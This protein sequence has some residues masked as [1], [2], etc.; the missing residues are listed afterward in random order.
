M[1]YTIPLFS[2]IVVASTFPNNPLAM[3]AY[4]AIAL[5]SVFLAANLFRR[6]S[7]P[8]M[9]QALIASS[10]ALIVAIGTCAFFYLR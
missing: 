1:R 2:V 8:M 10:F 6:T 9:R 7:P 3:V 4:I 5:Y